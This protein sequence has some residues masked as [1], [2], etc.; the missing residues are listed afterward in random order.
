M[1]D[2]LDAHAPAAGPPK[3]HRLTVDHLRQDGPSIKVVPSRG[4]SFGT[5]AGDA[6]GPHR[7]DYHQICWARSGSGLHLIDDRPFPIVPGTLTLIGRGQVHVFERGSHIFGASVSFGE[8][9]LVDRSVT[10]AHP[11]WLLDPHGPRTV[12]VPSSDVSH[13]EGIHAALAA[14]TSRPLDSRSIAVQ[15]HLLATLLLWVERWCQGAPTA[16]TGAD[17]ADAELYARF[18]SLLDRD[19][20]RRHDTGYYSSAL[21]MSPASLSR[22]LARVSGRTAKELITDRVMVEAARL[23]RFTDLGVSEVAVQIGFDDQFYFSRAFKRRHGK[24]PLAY[25]AQLR[26]V[27]LRPRPRAGGAGAA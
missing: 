24:S 1:T 11:G 20:A 27:P 9:L 16:S 14:E 13:L 12:P 8:E 3:A 21:A 10:H 7:H 19:F 6:R 17:D 26:R 22:T 18:L 4:D 23:L 15:R 5:V 25:R 2:P